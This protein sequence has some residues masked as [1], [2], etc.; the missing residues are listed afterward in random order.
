MSR[1]PSSGSKNIDYRVSHEKAVTELNK[2]LNAPSLKDF[3]SW[4]KKITH[5]V[6]GNNDSMTYKNPHTIK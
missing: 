6:I 2:E 5:H 3:I 4:L 1:F